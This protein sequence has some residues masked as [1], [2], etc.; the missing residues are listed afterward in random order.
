MYI[1]AKDNSKLISWYSAHYYWIVFFVYLASFFIPSLRAGVICSVLMLL[2]LIV[3]RFKGSNRIGVRELFFLYVLYNILSVSGYL[4]NGIPI[5]AYVKDFSN[6]FLPMIFFCIPSSKSFAKEKYYNLLLSSIT[7]CI[8][9]GLYFY[10]SKP[11]YY[12]DFLARTYMTYVKEY[13]LLHPRFNSFVGSTL[14]GTFCLTAMIISLNRILFDQ[15]NLIKYT[16]LYVIS[17]VAAFI[18]MQRS[19]MVIAIFILFISSLFSLYSSKK[20]RNYL[21]L[22]YIL[23]GAMLAF[24]ISRLDAS[25]LSTIN[26]RLDA[27]DSDLITSRSD[28]WFDT[29]RNS[30][31]IIFGSGLGSVGHKAIGFAKYVITDGSLFK[32]IAEFGIVGFLLFALIVFICIEKALKHTFFYFR[33]IS[34]IFIFLL[35]SIGSNTLSFQLLLPIFWLSLGIITFDNVTSSNLE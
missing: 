24:G 31:N 15:S 22:T 12:F 11:T 9:V 19:A 7:F 5:S 30:P 23:F 34:I 6:Q 13:Y 26:R 14:M 1:Y 2:F 25:I 4:Y 35:Q 21:Y 32:I 27:I 28:Q 33:E 17:F 20:S 18:T 10:I 16:I 3:L 8:I 29:I